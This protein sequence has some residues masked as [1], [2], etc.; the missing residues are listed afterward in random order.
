VKGQ[1]AGSRD[2]EVIMAYDWPATWRELENALE[3]AVTLT[4]GA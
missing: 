2:E 4:K 1:S 3:R